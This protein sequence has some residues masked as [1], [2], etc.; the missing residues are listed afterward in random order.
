M[1]FVPDMPTSG[2]AVDAGNLLECT[3]DCVF[4]LDTEWRFTLVN[5]RAAAELGA[6]RNVA[7]VNI[8]E[9]F[10]EA[11]GTPFEDHYRRAMSLRVSQQFEAFFAPSNAW[12]EVNANPS[13]NGISVWFRN[14]NERKA[15]E[16][17]VLSS[18]E[19]FRLAAKAT[20]DLIWDWDL[21]TDLIHWSE[22]INNLFG[23]ELEDFGTGIEWW[24][25][26]LHP[27]DRAR[28]RKATQAAIATGSH[29]TLEYRFLRAD[30]SYAPVLDRSYV[31]RD[32]HGTPVRMVGAI[33]DLTRLKEATEALA[34]RERQLETVFGQ[35][36]VGIMHFDESGG[37]LMVNDAFCRLLGRTADELAGCYFT[38]HTHPDDLEHNAELFKWSRESGRAFQVEKRYLHASGDPV[39]CAVSVSFVKDADDRVQSCIVIAEDV[40]ERRKMHDDLES[41]RQLLQSVID[42]VDDFIFVKDKTGRFVLTN[43]ALEEACGNLLGTT[44]SEYYDQEI[45]TRYEAGDREVIRTGEKR[46]MDEMMPVAGVPRTFQTV[47]V[48]LRGND[49]ISG[50]I[51]ISRDITDRIDA[52]KALKESEGLNRSIVEAS[53]DSIKLIDL[54]GTVAF[55]NRA[56]VEGLEAQHASFIIGKPWDELWPA[57]ARK[58]ARKALERAK[59]GGVSRFSCERETASKDRKWWDVV[60]SPV[61]GSDGRPVRLVSISRDITQQKRSDEQV[62]WGAT[63]DPLTGLPN[64][65]LFHERLVEALIRAEESYEQVGLLHLDVDHF[66]QINDSLGHDAGDALLKTFADRLKTFVRAGD[67]VA[68]LGGDE[69]AVILPGLRSDHDIGTTVE[70]ILL[71]MKEPF[72]HAD[73][74]LDC[75]ASIGASVYPRDG[76]SPE[77][78]LKNADT[79]LYAAKSAGRGGLMVFRPEMR[80]EVQKRSSMVAL[81]RDAVIEDRIEPFYQPKVD[82]RTGAVSGFEAL[83]RW[84]DIHGKLQ[85]PVQIAAAFEDLEVACGIS[86]RIL[87]RTVQDCRR[88]LDKGVEFG[89]VAINAAAAE[90]RRDNFAERVLEQLQ[91]A[92]VPTRRFQLEVTETVFL[93]RGAEHVERALKLLSAEGVTIAL[94]DFGTG[95]ASLQH[96]K[97][98]PVDVIKIDQSFVRDL[99]NGMGDAAIIEAVLKLGQSLG[100]RTVAEG[101]ETQAQ[102]DHLRRG[103]CDYGQGYFYSKAVAASRVPQLISSLSSTD[104]GIA[105]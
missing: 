99:G 42:G 52:E 56:G 76:A 4:F 40:S 20:N 66:K 58:Q 102:Q 72:I 11:L 23:Y 104:I 70:S 73:R 18:Q 3:S 69:F 95:Y 49:E 85:N 47:T 27:E 8:W 9:A 7:G 60:V 34:L 10:P 78:L 31:I 63:H 68:R 54:D 22:A 43:R 41:S 26:H 39:W 48:P 13:P 46:I 101:I 44:T 38:D 25:R 50:V 82:L 84:R 53:T 1:T 6:G 62:R 19:R 83:L 29:L 79:A 77:E 15:R 24:E 12:Y 14:I 65:T 64:R 32:S 86:D 17:L 90:F 93:G 30:G 35:A 33:Q 96:L 97:Q 55:V 98:F 91:K 81:A 74:I 28:V 87:E 59:Q 88:W 80:A 71:R 45:A 36:L 21:G 75:R 2:A 67:T 57:K 16:A 5:S 61:L 105:A 89:H 103:G 92:D 51:G 37:L 94:D 100:I